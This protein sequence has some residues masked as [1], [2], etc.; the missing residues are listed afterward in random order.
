MQQVS[1]FSEDPQ[2]EVE[3]WGTQ[4]TE[5]HACCGSVRSWVLSLAPGEICVGKNCV[6]KGSTGVIGQLQVQSS[7]DRNQPK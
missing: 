5:W 3:R 6:G 7:E 1:R 4:L 2:N